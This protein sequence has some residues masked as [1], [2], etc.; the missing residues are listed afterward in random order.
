MTASA[1]EQSLPE[2]TLTVRSW[3]IVRAGTW[4]RKAAAG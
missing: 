3:P 2:V 4:F 1:E